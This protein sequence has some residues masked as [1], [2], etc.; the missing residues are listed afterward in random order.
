MGLYGVKL[1][2]GALGVL[3][4]FFISV[5]NWSARISWKKRGKTSSTVPIFGAILLGAGIFLLLPGWFRLFFLSGLLIDRSSVLWTL[6]DCV[7]SGDKKSGII[8]YTASG[9]ILEAAVI[10]ILY[11]IF[12]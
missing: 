7:F 11:L 6:T 2:L 1:L 3:S 12:R 5:A 9:L 4:G 10:G 8:G